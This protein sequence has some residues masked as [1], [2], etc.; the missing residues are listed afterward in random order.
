MHKY[1]KYILVKYFIISFDVSRNSNNV[2]LCKK[3]NINKVI[4]CWLLRSYVNF[5]IN[6]NRQF[7]II[8]K[9]LFHDG[10]HYINRHKM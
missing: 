7:E 9:I 10:L 6:I 5:F 4:K 2:Y 3:M 8:T 1:C